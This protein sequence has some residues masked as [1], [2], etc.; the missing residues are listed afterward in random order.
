MYAHLL[1]QE[2]RKR[3]VRRIGKL[4][5]SIRLTKARSAID[6]MKDDLKLNA[7][8]FARIR[9]LPEPAGAGASL[10]LEAFAPFMH[11]AR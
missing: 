7:R 2:F 10:I 6:V 1:P 4:Y 8:C 9:A 11:A 3:L 5:S